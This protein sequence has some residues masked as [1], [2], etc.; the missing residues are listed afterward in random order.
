METT[1]Y[2]TAKYL[3]QIE[4]SELDI[5]NLEKMG[6]KYDDDTDYRYI[7]YK[8]GDFYPLRQ[9][10]ISIPRLK[11]IIKEMEKSGATHIEVE[12]HADHHG[13]VVQ[14]VLMRPA[15]EEE[16]AEYVEATTKIKDKESRIAELYQQIK[17]IE[18][19]E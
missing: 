7:F 4:E 9:E 2:Y 5:E 3:K 17:K 15:L 8:D 1:K 12:Y 11:K 13:Y 16:I 18:N 19:E 6:F 14:G 10:G